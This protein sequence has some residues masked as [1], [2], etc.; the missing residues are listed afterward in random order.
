MPSESDIIVQAENVKAGYGSTVILEKVSFGIK[1]GEVFVILGGSGCGKSTLLK[2]LIGLNPPLA[3][4][5]QIE[6][7]ELTEAEGEARNEILRKIGVSYQGGAL[8][9]SMTLTE[10]ITL[11]IEE[12]TK[13]PPEAREEMAWMKL[14]KMTVISPIKTI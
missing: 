5:I 7:E 4:K 2:H 3:G 8:F 10:N 12:F 14:P 9:G 1:K 13:L 11:P 6:G